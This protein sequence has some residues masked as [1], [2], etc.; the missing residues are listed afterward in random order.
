MDGRTYG[1]LFAD[2]SLKRH[3]IP[4]G[5]YRQKTEQPGSRLMVVVTNPPWNTR[6]RL[7]DCVFIIREQSGPWVV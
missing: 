2:F 5:L 7:T 1:T 6:L 4:V 3:W